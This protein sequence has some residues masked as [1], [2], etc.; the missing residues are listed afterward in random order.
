[1]HRREG[2]GPVSAERRSGEDRRAFERLGAL[3][4]R[5]QADDMRELRA[6]NYTLTRLVLDFC[7]NGPILPS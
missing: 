5:R 6:T 2:R 1:M 3:R 4:D 7:Q